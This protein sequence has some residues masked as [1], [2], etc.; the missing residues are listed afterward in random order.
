MVF[1]EY[2]NGIR[3]L[4][5][6]LQSS[7]Y[8]LLR[9]LRIYCYLGKCKM[10]ILQLSRDFC[11]IYIYML[12]VAFLN[13]LESGMRRCTRQMAGEIKANFIA[14][15]RNALVPKVGTCWSSK[16]G[17]VVVKAG[18]LLYTWNAMISVRDIL[19]REG[20]W[21]DSTVIYLYLY[22][23][24]RRA[25]HRFSKRNCQKHHRWSD[26][27]HERLTHLRSARYCTLLSI[28][29]HRHRI[30][31]IYAANLA[32]AYTHNDDP[33]HQRHGSVQP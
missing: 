3:M 16:L 13:G 15:A 31:H 28:H 21:H 29:L 2:R 24:M 5:Y 4:F 14:V 23:C 33:W 8:L 9:S 17:C 26:R 10:N 6:G 20:E 19:R 27:R 30:W 12:K 25:M 18:R 7:A 32:D 22:L 11:V 1:W